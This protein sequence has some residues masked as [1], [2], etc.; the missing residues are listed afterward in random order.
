MRKFSAFI[1]SI[2][3]ES[4]KHKKKQFLRAYEELQDALFRH[5]YF[6]VTNREIALDLTQETFLKVWEYLVGGNEVSNLKGFL[7]TTLNNKIIDH[8]RKKKS[9]SLETLS[10]AGFAPRDSG[11]EESII[12]NAEVTL[13]TAAIDSLSENY[14]DVLVMRYIDDLSITEIADIIGTTENN[15][16]VRINRATESLKKNLQL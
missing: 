2:Y 10:D 1:S 15:I 6:R 7:Y 3:M 8:Y 12:Q 4:L 14:K 5:C 16:S 13:I 9:D 11:M